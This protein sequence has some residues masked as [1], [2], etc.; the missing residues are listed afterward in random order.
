MGRYFLATQANLTGVPARYNHCARGRRWEL[1]GDGRQDQIP[2]LAAMR[3][4]PTGHFGKLSVSP[5]S[6]ALLLGF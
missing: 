3:W 6:S 5:S 1:L 2:E 4:D